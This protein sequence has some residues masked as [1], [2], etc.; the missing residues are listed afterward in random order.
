MARAI[1]EFLT[2]RD[3][4]MT[5]VLAAMAFECEM[6]RLFKKWVRIGESKEG[7]FFDDKAVEV[8][9][10]RYSDIETKITEVS[11]L[12]FPTGMTEFIKS[13]SDLIDILKGFPSLSIDKI[14]TDFKEKLFWP[15]NAILHNGKSNY[16]EDYASRC[17]NYAKL[18][19]V[20]LDQMDKHK[21]DSLI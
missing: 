15:R 21:R 3:Y 6:S 20:L 2:M 11:K 8:Y 9:L 4:S 10:R 1:Y 12:M 17:L 13:R 18:G 5:I 19:L 14:H 7:Y 16:D